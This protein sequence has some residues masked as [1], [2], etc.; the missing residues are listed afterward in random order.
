MEDEIKLWNFF[1]NTNDWL[2]YAEQKNV[3]MLTFITVQIGILGFI[4][5]NSSSWAY[6]AVVKW[7]LVCLALS[8]LLSAFSLLPF[9]RKG[10][11]KYNLITDLFFRFPI[12][13]R[14]EQDDLI[15]CHEDMVKYD[16]VD[17][18]K[19]INC[20]LNNKLEIENVS[21]LP[22]MIL[23]NARIWH[24][25]FWF[26]SKAIHVNIVGFI[27]IVYGILAK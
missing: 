13:R 8:F 4:S 19:K 5:K 6:P 22:D 10:D 3:H 17:F 14:E 2:R 18:R 25:K 7:G 16:F 21:L 20:Y 15:L 27:L 23:V 11:F 1:Q 9:R 12:D 24:V 26:F